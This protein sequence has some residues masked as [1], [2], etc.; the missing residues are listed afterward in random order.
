MLKSVKD[1]PIGGLLLEQKGAVELF[2]LILAK[3]VAKFSKI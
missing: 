3:I 2:N 1:S